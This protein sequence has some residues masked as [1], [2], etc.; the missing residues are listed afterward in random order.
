[1]GTVPFERA[2]LHRSIGWGT[3]RPDERYEFPTTATVMDRAAGLG[4]SPPSRSHDRGSYRRRRLARRHCQAAILLLARHLR[5][6]GRVVAARAVRIPAAR[7]VSPAD[8]LAPRR[9]ERRRDDGRRAAALDP[10]RIQPPADLRTGGRRIFWLAAT[11]DSDPGQLLLHRPEG[12]ADGSGTALWRSRLA[13]PVV[14]R[15]CGA[16][17]HGGE[18]DAGNRARRKSRSV[19][20]R[21]AERRSC[22]RTGS[23]RPRRARLGGAGS[24]RPCGVATA[25]GGRGDRGAPR[26]T[27]VS[28]R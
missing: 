10:P 7:A 20:R 23:A 2:M 11:A 8:R 15:G 24:R 3:N 17:G 18:A 6:G 21:S 19:L 1:M 22:R 4:T 27:L 5:R 14:L 12:S 25:G 16:V 28:G 26:R 9:T 13:A